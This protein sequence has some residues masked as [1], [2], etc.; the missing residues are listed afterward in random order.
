MS[1]IAASKPQAGAARKYNRV[2]SAASH[3]RASSR[4]TRIPQLRSEP[5][6]TSNGHSLLLDSDPAYLHQANSDSI[7]VYDIENA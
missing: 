2:A 6:T 4:V 3:T 1:A 7:D 5:G